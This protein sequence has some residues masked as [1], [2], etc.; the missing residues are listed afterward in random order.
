MGLKVDG[1]I[2]AKDTWRIRPGTPA[3]TYKVR[4]LCRQAGMGNLLG[5]QLQQNPIDIACVALDFAI[6]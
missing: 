5:F 2:E 6:L 4:M 1:R 3:N